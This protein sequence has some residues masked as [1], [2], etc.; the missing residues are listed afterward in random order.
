MV[1]DAQLGSGVDPLADGTVA[2]SAALDPVAAAA[3][4]PGLRRRLRR[5]VRPRARP[6]RRLRLRGDGGD[7]RL[8]RPRLRSDR[9][10]AVID[11]FFETTDRDSV[12]GTYS[13]DELGDTT[14][15]RMTGYELGPATAPQPVASSAR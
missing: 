2:T 8:D 9:P 13:I 1:T 15:D 14:L 7:P 5:G 12:L 6:L 11:A 3:R 4:R 10:P